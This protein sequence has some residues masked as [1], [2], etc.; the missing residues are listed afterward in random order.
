MDQIFKSRSQKYSK[1]PL[2]TNK[3]GRDR[4]EFSLGI[5]ESKGIYYSVRYLLI[6]HQI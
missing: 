1:I 3:E 4:G 5:N 6:S 2:F